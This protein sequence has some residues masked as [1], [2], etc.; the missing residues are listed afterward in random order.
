[1]VTDD[2][3]RYMQ[4][5]A[6]CLTL[7]LAPHGSRLRAGSRAYAAIAARQRIRSYMCA[8]CLGSVRANPPTHYAYT[9]NTG[10]QTALT[11]R[12]EPFRHTLRKDIGMRMTK[13]EA[14]DIA[15]TAKDMPLEQLLTEYGRFHAI[16]ENTPDWLLG[17][18]EYQAGK[19]HAW[20]RALHG[21]IGLCT[22]SAELLDAFKKELYGKNKPIRPDNIKEECGD[23]FFYLFLVM[24]AMDID[25]R[26]ILA[27]NVVKLAN[28]YIE[29]FDG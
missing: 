22:E 23:V 14:V 19:P 1:M 16:V 20:Q 18:I 21:S 28:R 8:G 5:A 3:L 9:S 2:L 12:A 25:L 7:S 29:R 10:P 11:V 6:I 15:Y 26:T 4:C 13:D 24:S 17:Q 27:D